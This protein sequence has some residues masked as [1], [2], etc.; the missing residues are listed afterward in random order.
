MIIQTLKK[1][2]EPYY[3]I[4][5]CPGLDC[6]F[7]EMIRIPNEGWVVPSE[8]LDALESYTWKRLTMER[9]ISYFNGVAELTSDKVVH[10]WPCDPRQGRRALKA[11]KIVVAAGARTHDVL[12][13]ITSKM[14]RMFWGAGS[15]FIVRCPG[16]V[17]EEVIR[18]PVR[19]ATCGMIVVPHEEDTF[20]I[21]ASSTVYKDYVG[22]ARMES[23][24]YLMNGAVEQISPD[25]KEATIIKQNYG[26]RPLT[27]DLMPLIG[28]LDSV[29]GIF[30]LSGTRRDGLHCSP[31]LAQDMVNRL[32]GSEPLVPDC[33]KPERESHRYLSV[34]EGIEQAY[35][36]EVNRRMAHGLPVYPDAIKDKIAKTYQDKGLT[37]GV[38]AELLGVI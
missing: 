25:F 22:E 29:P 31:L 11:N 7:T 32:L 24:R 19:A 27:E 23:L 17:Q 38:P 8:L 28:E 9:R 34:D 16:H 13:N 26:F 36:T 33:F 5:K 14:P 21:G 4:D 18:T 6:P 3:K 12:S 15:S 10:T 1:H 37:Y 30:V 2:K 20:F 35:S